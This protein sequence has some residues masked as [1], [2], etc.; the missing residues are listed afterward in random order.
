MGFEG[1]TKGMWN[2]GFLTLSS[3][4]RGTDILVLGLGRLYSTMDVVFQSCLNVRVS[5][6]EA[7]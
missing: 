7:E 1:H 3:L 2:Y 4:A 5:G 6:Q